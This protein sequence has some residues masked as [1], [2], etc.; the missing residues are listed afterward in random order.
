MLLAVVVVVVVVVVVMNSGMAA[1]A[2]VPPLRHNRSF[3]TIIAGH[4]N[5]VAG[6]LHRNGG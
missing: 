6:C 1:G 5:A 3:A 2:T 4:A